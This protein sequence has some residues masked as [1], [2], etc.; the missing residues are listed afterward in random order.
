MNGRI[1]KVGARPERDQRIWR[2]KEMTGD[3]RRWTRELG[4]RWT[5]LDSSSVGVEE[6]TDVTGYWQGLAVEYN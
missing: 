5:R 1:R 2:D 3:G 4:E 6:G